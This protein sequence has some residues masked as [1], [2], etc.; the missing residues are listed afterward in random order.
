MLLPGNSNKQDE[1]FI[2]R[3]RSHFALF[4]AGIGTWFKP[5]VVSPLFEW[6]AKV[7]DLVFA[8][9]VTVREAAMRK[10]DCFRYL[11]A[12]VLDGYRFIMQNYRVGDKICLFGVQRASN[13]PFSLHISNIR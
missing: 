6:G 10:L 3:C 11:D 12:H 9:Y 5:G 8:W 7:L 4:K 13:S 1:A 2:S